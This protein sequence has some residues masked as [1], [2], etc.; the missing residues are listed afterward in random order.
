MFFALQ[1]QRVRQHA[2]GEQTN[3]AKGKVSA[4]PAK[5]SIQA[6]QADHLLR[7]LRRTAAT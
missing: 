2:A 4:M 6:T 1:E 3:A 5:R 7:S